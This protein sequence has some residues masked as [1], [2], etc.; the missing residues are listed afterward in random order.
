V[1]IEAEAVYWY[2]KA[3]EQG[4]PP[5]EYDLGWMVADGRGVLKNETEAK[6]WLR[7]AA[8]SGFEVGLEKPQTELPQEILD[9]FK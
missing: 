8:E 5:A 6:G 3:A 4:H 2:R 7:R 1:K 9:L